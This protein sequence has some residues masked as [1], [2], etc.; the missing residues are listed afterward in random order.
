[1]VSLSQESNWSHYHSLLATG[2]VLFSRGDLAAK[3]DGF[4]D[5]TRWLLGDSAAAKFSALKKPVAEAPQTVFSESGYYLLGARYGEPD[6]VRAVVDCGPIGYLSIAAH[7]HADA[8]AMTLSAGGSELLIDP[9]TYA[10]HTQEKWRNYFRGT[11]A[12]NTV[13]VDRMDQSTLGGNFLWLQ[14]ANSICE[15]AETQGSI[16][17]FCG[18]HDG[19][20]RLADPVTHKREVLFNADANCFDVIDSL[21]CKGQHEVELCWHIAEDC[22]VSLHD[23]VVTIVGKNATLIL[24]MPANGLLPQLVNGQEEPPGGWIS[25][26]FDYKAPTNTLVW[27][28]VLQGESRLSTRLQISFDITPR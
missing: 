18:W 28:G 7:G 21:L 12:H 17:K 25:R 10:Y 16:Q 3:A 15:L 27:K 22:H 5:K 8:L 23:R 24:T 20:Q 1:M 4:D 6:E 14:K 13:R 9:G 11:F 26:S 19:Y 2:A